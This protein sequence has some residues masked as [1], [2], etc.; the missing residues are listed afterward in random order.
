M[1]LAQQ[2]TGVG[3][4][5]N[6]RYLQEWSTFEEAT[7]ERQPGVK[8]KL[9]DLCMSL[10]LSLSLPH[11]QHSLMLPADIDV[12]TLQ[13][14]K[15]SASPSEFGSKIIELFVSQSPPEDSVN[16]PSSK[17]K[18]KTTTTLPFPNPRV[19][20]TR[21]ELVWLAAQVERY[22]VV[23]KQM[24]PKETQSATD[25]FLRKPSDIVKQS[26]QFFNLP[27][28]CIFSGYADTFYFFCILFYFILF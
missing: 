17:D 27:D 3:G 19:I 20:P 25:A 12:A 16:L 1:D 7:F 6:T 15:S 24:M 5:Q 18:K 8:T 9:I 23:P 13:A 22:L 11:G 21:P 10:P 26:P 14:L 4:E 28:A 2:G